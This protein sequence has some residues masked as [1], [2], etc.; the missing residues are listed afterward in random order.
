M[1]VLKGFHK[2]SRVRGYLA[3]AFLLWS[4]FPHFQLITHSHVSGEASHFHNTLSKTDIANANLI[5]QTLEGLEKQKEEKSD[6]KNLNAVI[7]VHKKTFSGLALSDKN[8]SS[9]HTHYLEEAN[10]AGIGT[11][12]DIITPPSPNFIYLE[13]ICLTPKSTF[14]SLHQAR[15]PPISLLA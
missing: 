2:S 8:S 12:L 13:K 6:S 14:H 7:P 9:I 11:F 10:L 1:K 15:A 4:I 3:L 5:L